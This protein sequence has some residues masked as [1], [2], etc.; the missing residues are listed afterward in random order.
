MFILGK[1]RP[2]LLPFI[3]PEES[4]EENILNNLFCMTT[5][6]LQSKI[7]TQYTKP[8]YLHNAGFLVASHN[9]QQLDITQ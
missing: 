3:L 4:E 9:T 7:K 6:I 5:D 1:N 2:L 8:S